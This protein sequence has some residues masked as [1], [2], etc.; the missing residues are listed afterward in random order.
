MTTTDHR[1][2]SAFE[3]A[4]QARILAHP[5]VTLYFS[6]S[7]VV[8]NG[9]D[10]GQ[11]IGEVTQRIELNLALA[12][13]AFYVNYGLARPWWRLWRKT[14]TMT[15]TVLAGFEQD[16]DAGQVHVPSHPPVVLYFSE[17]G[18]I[19]TGSDRGQDIGDV[20]QRLITEHIKAGRE[21]GYQLGTA[22]PWWRLWRETE[23]MT[24]TVLG[25][26]L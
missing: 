10:R 25:E 8:L 23:T 22:R 20:T 3:D 26:G 16:F 7:N 6:R 19:L 2:L 12:G 21:A 13:R 17:Q 4:E 14:M 24:V 11:D 1:T 18:L 5:P 15:V 9:P